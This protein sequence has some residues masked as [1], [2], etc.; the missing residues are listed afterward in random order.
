VPELRKE[1]F[2]ADT[3]VAEALSGSPDETIYDTCKA[4]GRTLVTLDLDFANPFRFPPEDSAG[5]VVVRPPKAALSSIRATL[6]SVIAQL[7]TGA[8]KGKLW[9]VEAGRIR[10]HD[11]DD[12]SG[13]S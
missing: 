9:I 1:G 6:W 13:T 8:V 2:D 3:V 12:A 11:P 7:K 10:E 5:I 4:V